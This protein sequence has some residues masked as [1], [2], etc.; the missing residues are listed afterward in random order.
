M[1]SS[2]IALAVA[3]IALL[4]G[5]GL[6]LYDQKTSNERSLVSNGPVSSD[7]DNSKDEDQTNVAPSPQKINLKAV[8]T[9]ASGISGRVYANSEFILTIN[10][11]LPNL[12]QGW[13]YEGWAYKSANESS[14]PLFLGKLDDDGGT[15]YLEYRKGE[16]MSSYD[17]IYVYRE[18]NMG[19][20]AGVVILEGQF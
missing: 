11:Q 4:L 9:E 14:E 3:I 15:Y 7:E 8:G 2:N 13:S 12:E 1:K 20:A 6:Y 5:G 17:H 19:E 10:A 16:D 18:N